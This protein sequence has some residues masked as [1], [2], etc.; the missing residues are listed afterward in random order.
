MKHGACF[1]QNGF[2]LIEL[3]VAGSIAAIL[4]SLALP[5]YTVYIAKARQAE[6][7][8]SL[9]SIHQLQITYYDD[10][11]VYFAG[12]LGGDETQVDTGDCNLDNDLGFELTECKKVRY[13]Y[14]S[15][16][17]TPSTFNATATSVYQAAASGGG[18]SP[19]EGGQQG[20]ITGCEEEDIWQIDED[21]VLTHPSDAL[22][23]CAY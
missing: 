7:K 14:A 23:L 21:R 20:L 11:N 3:V 6:A 9:N 17:P 5:R 1:K 13:N 10:R 18:C 4:G 8:L 22:K 16:T 2:T 12:N 15:T 19:D